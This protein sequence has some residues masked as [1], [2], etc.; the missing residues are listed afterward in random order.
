MAGP[1]ISINVKPDAKP[2]RRLTA[3]TIPQAMNR[4]AN[5]QIKKLLKNGI[6]TK[7]DHPTSWIIPGFF[8][9]KPN[10]WGGETSDRLHTLE[11][12]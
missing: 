2:T 7:V 1:H 11:H 9:Q 4:D 12:T 3:R 10:R 8:V 5:A 6:I